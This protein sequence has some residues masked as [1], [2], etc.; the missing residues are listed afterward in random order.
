[1]KAKIKVWSTN[2]HTPITNRG[3]AYCNLLVDV[4]FDCETPEQAEAETR[5]LIRETPGGARG[6]FYMSDHPNQNTRL[7]WI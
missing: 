5:R 3:G 6:F 2:G 4:E 7:R 1:M